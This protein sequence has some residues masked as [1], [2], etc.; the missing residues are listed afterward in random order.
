MILYNVTINID[1]EVHDEW[2]QWMKSRHI[3]DVLETGLFIEGK[4]MRVLSAEPGEGHTYS[5]QYLLESM[6]HYREYE[7]KHADS[8]RKEH[9]KR[10]QNKFV[11]FRTL[12]E[13][14]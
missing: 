4:L 1:P 9:T 5:V 10:Y 3:P 11:A 6:E 2:L 12:L 8:L 13:S 7:E 14:A